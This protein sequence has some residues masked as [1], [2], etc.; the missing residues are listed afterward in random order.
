MLRFAV[1]AMMALGL[2]GFGAVAWIALRPPPPPVIVAAVAAAPPV[3]LHAMIAA[4]GPLHAGALL[5]PDDL[6]ATQVALLPAG[7]QEDGVA[8]RAGLIGAMLRRSL[9]PDE[10]LL[11]ADVMRPGDHGFL[12]AVLAP[13]LRAASVAVDAVS[14]S[15]GLI[16]PGDHVDLIL[17]QALDNPALP[18]ARRIAAETVLSDVR[19]IAIDQLLAHGVAP[20][21]EQAGIGRTVT[22]EVTGP[23]AERI[24]VATRLGRLSLAVRAAE[25]PPASSPYASSPHGLPARVLTTWGGDVSPALSLPATSAGA[26]ASMRLYQGVADAKEIKF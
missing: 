26:G 6:A 25:E 4:A 20:A 5:K 18:P 22:L 24:A 23:D 17:T 9:G 16:W 3:A 7:T 15:A 2:G 11:A 1:F 19:V 21:S 12:A 10:P 8:A 13:G 14:G